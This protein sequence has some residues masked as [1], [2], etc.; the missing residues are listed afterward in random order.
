MTTAQLLA[1]ENPQPPDRDSG[2]SLELFLLGLVSAVLGLAALLAWRRNRHD[3][4]APTSRR[5]G[6]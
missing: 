5:Y 2:L 1:A 6:A 3:A 4:S